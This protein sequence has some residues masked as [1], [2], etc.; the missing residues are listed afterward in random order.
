MSNCD[1]EC[2]GQWISTARAFTGTV[3]TTT[4]WDDVSMATNCGGCSAN[5]TYRY[6]AQQIVAGAFS[7]TN[8]DGSGNVNNKTCA[9][10]VNL[11]T[12][13]GTLRTN[14][15]T[16]CTETWYYFDNT[17]T[18]QTLTFDEE[19]NSFDSFIFCY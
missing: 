2:S 13:T 14:D 16:Q 11:G 3:G 5:V 17:A 4:S 9:T 15:V 8:L 6:D 19:R 7:G 12:T 1:E 10:A 18:A